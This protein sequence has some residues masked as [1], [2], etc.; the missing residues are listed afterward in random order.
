LPLALLETWAYVVDRNE[1]TQGSKTMASE[2]ING[3]N[4]IDTLPPPG[5][6]PGRVFVVV[7]GSQW[8]SDVNWKRERAGIA[9]TQNDGFYPEH[10]AQLERDGNMDPGTGK[11]TFWMPWNLPPIPHTQ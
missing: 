6:R 5:E 10:I 11:V 2:V 8:H 4:P 9:S 3:W 1:I 7:E